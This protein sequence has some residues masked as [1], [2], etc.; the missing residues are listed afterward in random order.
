MGTDEIRLP[1]ILIAEDDDDDRVLMAKA[2]ALA[3][4]PA[5]TRFVGDGDELLDYLFRRGEYAAPELSPRPS[6]I[7]LDLRMPRRDGLSAATELKADTRFR[8]TP[9]VVL[10]TSTASEDVRSAYDAGASAYITKPGSKAGL[11]LI[12]GAIRDYW[13]GAVTLPPFDD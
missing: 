11:S 2:I 9:I 13:F 6:L 8:R 10:T 1:V 7:L 5:D 4:I 3:Q 12:A